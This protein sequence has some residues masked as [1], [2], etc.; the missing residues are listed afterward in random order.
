M[1][2]GGVTPNLV[3]I[4]SLVNGLCKPGRMVLTDVVTFTSLIHAMCRANL[5]R[6][7]ALM[8]QMREGG[9]R[10]NE[11]ALIDGF[12]KKGF[13]DDALL[14]MKEMRGCGE[15]ALS[16]H[17]EMIKIGVLPDVVTYTRTKEAQRLLFKF[18]HE[19]PVP[20]NIK[21]DALMHCCRKAEFKS[22]L[23]LLEGFCMEGLMDE[24]DTL[25]GSVYSALIHAL[26]RGGNVMKDLSFHK[27]TFQRGFA[28][29]PTTTISLTR[30]LFEKG[31][32]VEAGQV[33]QQF[34]NCCSLAAVEAS[35]SLID[36]NLKEDVLHNMARDGLLP[37]SRRG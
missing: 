28:P 22:V 26:C 6:A 20:A 10:M 3:T 35:K 8:K 13:L 7:M 5:G 16:L 2:E 25:D 31:M 4:N 12:C 9:I 37:S 19:D 32:I 1:W 36:L 30:G 24:A 17:D 11:T 23:G 34:L 14:I 33:T 27:Q 29:N 18:Y 15:K 21:Y